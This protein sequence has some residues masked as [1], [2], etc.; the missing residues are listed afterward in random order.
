ML[1]RIAK[2]LGTNGLRKVVCFVLLLLALSLLTAFDRVTG[3]QF[4]DVVPW[5]FAILA[6]GNVMEYFGK[7]RL[8]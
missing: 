3:Q 4:V 1:D 8:T 7:K 6:G 2:F 5:L